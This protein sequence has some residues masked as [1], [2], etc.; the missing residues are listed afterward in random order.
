MEVGSSPQDPRKLYFF[1]T[2]GAPTEGKSIYM[3]EFKKLLSEEMHSLD[4]HIIHGH[5]KI[6]KSGTTTSVH[7]HVEKNRGKIK[8]GLL[9]ENIYYLFWN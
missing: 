9:A 5:E 7:T 3:G 8:P 4:T 2:V 1:R 6:F